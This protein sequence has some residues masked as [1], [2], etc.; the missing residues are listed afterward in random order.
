M[1]K[2]RQIKYLVLFLFLSYVNAHNTLWIGNLNLSF[3]L[4]TVWFER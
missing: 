4:Y 3:E 2:P 1:L